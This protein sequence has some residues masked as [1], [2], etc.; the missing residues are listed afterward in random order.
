MKQ[1]IQVKPRTKYTFQKD[2]FKLK[3]KKKRLVTQNEFVEIL[4]KLYKNDK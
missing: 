4:L 2:R 3:I 1:T